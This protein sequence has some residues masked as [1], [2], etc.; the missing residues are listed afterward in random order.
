MHLDNFYE[1]HDLN[2]NDIQSHKQTSNYHYNG[3]KFGI[4]L[5]RRD[6]LTDTLDGCGVWRIESTN[7]TASSLT[8]KDPGENGG[9]KGMACN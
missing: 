5:R 9:K 4:L 7:N 2:Y 3:V 8:I 1:Y 6:T